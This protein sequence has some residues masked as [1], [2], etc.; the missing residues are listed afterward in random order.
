M[1]NQILW[2]SG[3]AVFVAFFTTVFAQYYFAPTLEARKQRLLKRSEHTAQIV[4]ELNEM[5]YQMI[6]V[7]E[8]RMK[9]TEF[10]NSPVEANW[11][12]FQSLADSFDPKTN[13]SH[14]N[15]PALSTEIVFH[16]QHAVDI[17]A[18]ISRP[19]RSDLS[20]HIE[21]IRVSIEAIDPVN[22]PWSRAYF[23]YAAVKMWRVLQMP[24]NDEA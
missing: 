12:H 15:L 20:S 4:T 11:K 17:F 7:L 18:T 13:L 14:S 16:C 6:L 3:T 24:E 2:T 10:F 8:R 9:L 23:R 22:L 5:R 21:Y 19:R 1:T